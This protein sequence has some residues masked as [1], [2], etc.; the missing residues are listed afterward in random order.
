M[1]K[2]III[3]YYSKSG[4]TKAIAERIKEVFLTLETKDIEI[5]LMDAKTIDLDALKHANGYI[6]GTPNYFSAPAGYIKIFFDEFF[7]DDSL[8]GRPIFCF[9]THGG[10]GDIKELK[11]MSDWLKLTTVGPAVVVKGTKIPPRI[12]GIIE[13]NLKEMSKLL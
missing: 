8:K 13:K 9:I 12:L 5:K 6:I 3:L 7:G 10:S 11:D 1:T 4:T 2:I